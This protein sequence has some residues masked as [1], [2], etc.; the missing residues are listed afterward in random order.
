MKN[1]YASI[2]LIVLLA[3]LAIT[4]TSACIDTTNRN[5]DTN[6][7]A[8]NTPS[9]T[10]TSQN[11][12]ASQTSV[13][14]TATNLG[15]FQTLTSSYGTPTAP[16]T[17]N[18]FVEYAIYCENIN[19]KNMQMGNTNYLKL[20]DTNGNIYSYDSFTFSVQRQVNGTTLKGLSYELNTQP[21]DKLSG[22]IVFQ[23]PQSATPKSLTYDDYTNRITINL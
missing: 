14:V 5:T 20:R 8:S 19:A 7:A 2:G 3:I 23:I 15:S 6:Q 12:P 21:G 9:G 4:A 16:A 17:G 22:L 18:K 13:R 1:R 11:T 10:P